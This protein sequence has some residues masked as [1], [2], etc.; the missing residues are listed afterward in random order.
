MIGVL[1]DESKYV[2]VH[3]S[4]PR[5]RRCWL[6]EFFMKDGRRIEP[7]GCRSWIGTFTAARDAATRKARDIAQH[8]GLLFVRVQVQP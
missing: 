7:Y 8:R 6:F 3:G 2:A 4:R 1:Y 5:G